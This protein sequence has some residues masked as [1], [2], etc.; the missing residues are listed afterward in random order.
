MNGSSVG[1]NSVQNTGPDAQRRVPT[2]PERPVGTAR[3]TPPRCQTLDENDGAQLFAVRPHTSIIDR[4]HR[5]DEEAL[6]TRGLCS[7]RFGLA[8]PPQRR[9]LRASGQSGDDQGCPETRSHGLSRRD[10][11]EVLGIFHQRVQ[12]LLAS[13][14]LRLERAGLRRG[15]TPTAGLQTSRSCDVVARRARRRELAR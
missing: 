4:A 6:D 1:A 7:F 9:N 8:G 12:Q 3:P 10:T 5:R 15:I 11:S 14:S 13:S 2:V